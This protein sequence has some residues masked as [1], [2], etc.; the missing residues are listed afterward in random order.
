MRGGGGGGMVGVVNNKVNCHLLFG[1]F[2]A[3]GMKEC[4]YY[5]MNVKIPLSVNMNAI[6]GFHVLFPVCNTVYL[7]Y[8]DTSSLV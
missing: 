6:I 8:L 5:R 3:A 2:I 1:I 4:S 7:T